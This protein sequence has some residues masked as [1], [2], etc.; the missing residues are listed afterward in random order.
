M[1]AGPGNNGG[2]GFVLARC[3]RGFHD[4]ARRLPRRSGTPAARRGARPCR[5]ARRRRHDDQDTPHQVA[6]ADRRRDVRDRL[7][8]HRCPTRTATGS[9]GPTSSP[10]PRSR[11]TFRPDCARTSG[12]ATAP[13]IRADA[14]AT[15]IALKP[16]LLTAEGPD[17]CGS[18]SVHALGLDAQSRRQPAEGRLLEWPAWLSALPEAFARRLRRRRTR[19]RSERWASIGGA[20]GNARRR[21]ARRPRGAALRRRQGVARLRRARPARPSIRRRPSS[22]SAMREAGARC[23][24]GRAGRRCG[25]GNDDSARETLL[26]RDRVASAARAR[27]RCAEPPRRR[28]ALRRA[29]RSRD[30]ATIVTPHPA[31][32][33]RLLGYDV[34]AHAA[35]SPRR[36]ACDRARAAAHVVLKGAGS[37]LAHPDG[38]W[39]INGS[40]NPALAIAG[41]GDVLSGL[42]GALSRSASRRRAALARSP[43]ACTA[44]PP[45]RWSR[46]ASGRS[47]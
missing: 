10:R 5:V 33:A 45:T 37:V 27:C 14:T 7:R 11:S 12:I 13:A 25:L 18:V 40:G 31:E 1:L 15:F 35:R 28:S 4:V 21:A 19:E 24:P 47:A 44:P 6:R 29:T 43:C 39:D 36:R 17:L 41:T 22:C 3:L 2:D 8:S 46:A 34:T 42:L 32:A 20:C 30:A 9:A 26:E 23:Q 38:T 16:G